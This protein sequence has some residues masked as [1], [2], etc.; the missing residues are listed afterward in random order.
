[1]LSHL[2]TLGQYNRWAGQRLLTTC[3]A[4]DEAEYMKSRPAAYGSIHGTLNHILLADNLW[5]SRLSG[6]A[7]PLIPPLDSILYPRFDDVCAARQE[8]DDRLTH[9]FAGLTEDDLD[10]DV[11]YRTRSGETTSTKVAWI[12]TNMFHHADHHRGQ[13]HDMLTQI[14]VEP[15]TMGVICF[16]RECP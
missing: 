5:L 11:I 14:P 4:L 9:Y 13:I 12:L 15:P 8:I 1:M 7:D 3:E 2:R 6:A 16:L 10:H